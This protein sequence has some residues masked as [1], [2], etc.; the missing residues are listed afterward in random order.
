MDFSR[1]KKLIWIL[2]IVFLAVPIGVTASWLVTQSMIEA[3]SDV[4]FCGGCHSMKPV[5][6]AYREDVH[7]GNNSHGVQVKCSECHLPHNNNLVYL[8]AKGYTGMKDVFAELTYADSVDWEAKR[9]ER[10]RYVYDSG[11]LTCHSNLA[12]AEI[13]N[14][15]GVLAHQK[16][17]AGRID[18]QCVSCHINVGHKDLSRHRSA[19]QTGS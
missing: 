8:V 11:C 9:N 4:E 12:N 5:A 19:A 16:Y 7:G 18:R 6:A 1:R 14:E 17:F 3:T 13:N 10:E 15:L 2:G